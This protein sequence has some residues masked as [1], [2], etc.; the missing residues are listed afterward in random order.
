MFYR[1]LNNTDIE[2]G[3]FIYFLLVHCNVK[4]LK[5][6]SFYKNLVEGKNLP[7]V[8]QATK[9]NIDSSELVE[10]RN[11]LKSFFWEAYDAMP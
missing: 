6:F 10:N 5:L 2:I 8:V 3:T 11:Y 9:N 4:D 7:S 1:I